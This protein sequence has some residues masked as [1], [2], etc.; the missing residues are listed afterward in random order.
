MV[1][2]DRGFCDLWTLADFK[3]FSPIAKYFF[4]Y[5]TLGW[6]ANNSFNYL[7]ESKTSKQ[8]YKLVMCDKNDEIVDMKASLLMGAA[9]EICNIQK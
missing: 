8:C 1:I 3:F 6:Q 9:R 2:A 5:G 7:K 4:K